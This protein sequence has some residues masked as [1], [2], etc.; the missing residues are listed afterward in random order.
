MSTR[1]VPR[2]FNYSWGGGQ[3]LEE[4]S[5]LGEH[6]EP[7]LQLLRYEGGDH[8]GVE[9]V[10]FC[11]YNLRGAFQRHPLMLGAD[12][13]AKMREALKETPRLREL[14]KELVKD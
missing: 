6:S 4:A 2:P 11:F 1:K 3:I 14:L 9:S 7:A 5:F 13:I 12:D 10:R 8:D